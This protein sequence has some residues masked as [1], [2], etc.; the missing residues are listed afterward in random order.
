MVTMRGEDEVGEQTELAIK[1]A[2]M[3]NN[4][5]YGRYK[6]VLEACKDCLSREAVSSGHYYREVPWEWT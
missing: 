5:Q 4:I 2:C 6:H 3:C 1:L